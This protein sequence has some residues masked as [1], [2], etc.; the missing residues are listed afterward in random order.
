MN[1]PQCSQGVFDLM[2]P[3][4]LH[5]HLRVIGCFDETDVKGFASAFVTLEALTDVQL[6]SVTVPLGSE[7]LSFD[8]ESLF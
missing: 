6:V 2:F 5:S 4:L 8:P 3:Q 1:F 7:Q